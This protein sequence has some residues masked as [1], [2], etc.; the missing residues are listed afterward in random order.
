MIMSNMVW[1]EFIKRKIAELGHQRG[2][3]LD[4]TEFANLV[5]VDAPRISFWK[6]GERIPVGEVLDRVAKVLGPEAYDAAGKPARLPT[7]P[8][9][10]L[11]VDLFYMLP[12]EDRMLFV[13]MAEDAKAKSKKGMIVRLSELLF[14]HVGA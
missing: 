1:A 4:N 5:G 3:N 2:S 11:A 6:R 12:E 14:A 10:R 9:G 8:G 13:K 7:D